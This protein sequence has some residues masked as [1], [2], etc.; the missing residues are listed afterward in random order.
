MLAG[1]LAVAWKL[2]GLEQSVED[3][4]RRI[5]QMDGNRQNRR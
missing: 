2:G 4:E 3:L 1:L 5:D